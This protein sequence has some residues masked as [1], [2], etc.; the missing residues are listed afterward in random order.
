[1]RVLAMETASETPGSTERGSL[2]TECQALVAAIERVAN[3][4]EFNGTRPINAETAL[5]FKIGTGPVKIGT[6]TVATEDDLTF[7]I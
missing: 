5:T 6:G 4:T 2:D 7:T 1:M 3:E